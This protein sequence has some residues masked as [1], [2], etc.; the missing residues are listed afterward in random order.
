VVDVRDVYPFE[1]ER[2]ELRGKPCD[3]GVL[4]D[5]ERRYVSGC[6]DGK[7]YLILPAADYY[8]LKHRYLEQLQ[9]ERGV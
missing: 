4:E 9:G 8:E 7:R 6:I 3:A 1:L 5:K 2:E